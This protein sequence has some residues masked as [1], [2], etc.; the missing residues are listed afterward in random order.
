MMCMTCIYVH[1]LYISLMCICVHVY[2][3][4]YVKKNSFIYIYIKYICV[5]G[6]VGAKESRVLHE[7]LPVIHALHLCVVNELR[8]KGQ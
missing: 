2:V 4:V 3:C 6:T 7:C 5:G 1:M 8:H